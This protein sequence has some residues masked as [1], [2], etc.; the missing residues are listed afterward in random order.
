MRSLEPCNWG[1][2]KLCVLH[3]GHVT[4]DINDEFK[5]FCGVKSLLTLDKPVLINHLHVE[6]I[7][8]KA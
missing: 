6:D 2:R 7:V 1:E 5:C 8:D 4:E 3:T